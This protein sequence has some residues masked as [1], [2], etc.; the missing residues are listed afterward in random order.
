MNE[1]LT[2]AIQLHQ[3]GR[4]AEA[5]RAYQA[6]LKS[7]PDNPLLIHNIGLTYFQ[8]GEFEPAARHIQ[9]A[10]EL[11]PQFAEAHDNLGSILNQLGRYREAAE[12]H[13]NAISCKPDFAQAHFNLGN[14][15]SAL[16]DLPDAAQAYR[17]AAE[18][19]PDFGVAH[20]NLGNTLSL[21]GDHDAALLEYQEAVKLLPDMHQVH[22]NLANTLGSLNRPEEARAC[23]QEALRLNPNLP[24]AHMNLGLLFKGIGDLPQAEAAFR[25]ATELN[26]DF[27]EAQNN[28]GTTLCA[29][30][31]PI[32]AVPH[33]KAALKPGSTDATLYNNLAGAL[34]AAENFSEAIET[35]RKALQF[36]EAHPEAASNLL[37][38]LLKVCDFETIAPL[39]ADIHD[40]IAA[41]GLKDASWETYAKYAYLS[42]LLEFEPEVLT[43]VHASIVAASGPDAPPLCRSGASPRGSGDR[44]RIAYVSPSLGNHPV[45]HVTRGI[46]AAHDRNDF[47]VF[48]YSLSD[49]SLETTPYHKDIRDGC[50]AF[51]DL[52]D[53]STTDAAHRIA[54]DQIDILIDINGYMQ[55]SALRILQRRV[56]PVQVFWLGHAGGL[57]L[58][59]ID[60]LI[61]DSIVIP[62]GEETIYAEKIIR[63]PETYHPADPHPI[64]DIVSERREFGLSE[65]AFVFCGFNNP[66][67]INERCLQL[68]LEIM[69]RVPGSELWLSNQFDVPETEM[70]LRKYAERQGVEPDRLVFASRVADKAH[71]LA[72]HSLADLF[73]DT[74]T[75]NAATTALDA[76]W[77]GLPVLTVRGNAFPSR[78]AETML[79]AVGLHEL[80]TE[81]ESAFVDLAT[82]LATT[83]SA[84]A[85]VKDR[86]QQNVRTHP[87]FDTKR[88]VAH[89]ED[90]YRAIWERHVSG[91]PPANIDVARRAD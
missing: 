6:L 20:F 38:A 10:I 58:P 44:I 23:Y 43:R 16:G 65:D 26:P 24:E 2:E 40:R 36:D 13:R 74:L 75:V 22:F 48:A 76:L 53:A 82:T 86:L 88:F 73:L 84:L 42:P 79:N 46:Y 56:A 57:G 63:L 11:Q 9:R 31:R 70:N 45:G 87:M 50:D 34:L 78:M 66:Q 19:L 21:L 69:S 67:K 25:K 89:L 61:A 54:S 85:A 29:L 49:R 52:S 60:Y 39:R 77:S 37:D 59:W 72:R 55:N 68:W 62:S 81:S 91:A 5:R 4:L 32:D 51:I 18:I 41:D 33:F 7:A 28:L 12:A 80:V 15:L 30:G 47:E 83:P 64:A 17:T 71:H 90:G 8:T 1:A 3:S 35:Y 27:I 14:A